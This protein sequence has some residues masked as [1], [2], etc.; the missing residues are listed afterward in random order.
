MEVV[1]GQHCC[2][3]KSPLPEL[4][5]R[6]ERKERRERERG[7]EQGCAFL[8]RQSASRSTRTLRDSL[9]FQASSWIVS[10]APPAGYRRRT[11]FWITEDIEQPERLTLEI[12][13]LWIKLVFFYIC[14]FGANADFDRSIFR[15]SSIFSS[16][17]T[18]FPVKISICVGIFW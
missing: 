2:G 11:C 9:C 12:M 14:C 8:S 4:V 6:R 17:V 18:S 15:Y 13:E 1:K 3:L 16:T 5:R 7:R 10:P